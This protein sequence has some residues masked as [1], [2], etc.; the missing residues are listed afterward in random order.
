MTARLLALAVFVA[1]AAG[2][3]TCNIPVFR[4]ALERWVSDPYEILLFHRGGDVK[5]LLDEFEKSPANAVLKRVDLSKPVADEEVRNLAPPEGAALPW[6]V[7]RYPENSGVPEPAWSGP[8][9]ART[10]LDSPMRREIIRRILAGDSA[11]WLLLESGDASKDGAAEALLKETLPKSEK[12]LRLPELTDSPSDRLRADSVPLRLAFSILRL[13]R[14]DPAEEVLAGLLLRCEPDLAKG[15]DPIAFP[16]FGRGRI[17]PPLIGKGITAENVSDYC[18]FLCGACSCEAKRFNPGLDLLFEVDWK[19][20]FE[21][22]PPAPAIPAVV[23][24]PRVPDPPLPPPDPG[25]PWRHALWAG[26]ALAGLLVLV[27][28]WRLLRRC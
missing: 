19:E 17:L 6:A 18:A 2:S 25:L 8:A 7:V 11:V 21:A 10:I 23:L 1:P 3:G 20:K 9:A 27:T 16:F 12:A 15:S 4:Y 13:S 22:P 14:R 26:A 5:P 28:G 24:K